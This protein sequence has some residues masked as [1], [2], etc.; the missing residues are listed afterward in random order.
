M[1][2]V[3][4]HGIRL[5]ATTRRLERGSRVTV[6]L[7]GLAGDETPFAFGGALYPFKVSLA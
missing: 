2:V 5:V 1:K 7:Q 6:R 4:L 3:S